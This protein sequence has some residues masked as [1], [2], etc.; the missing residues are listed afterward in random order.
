MT[1]IIAFSVVLWIFIDRVKKLWKG[2]KYGSIIT[3]V[4]A[5]VCGLGLAFG[6]GL[7]LLLALD[8]QEAVTIGGQIFAGLALAGGSSVIN[9]LLV[10][11]NGATINNVDAGGLS[12]NE[13][14]EQVERHMQG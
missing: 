1:M 12:L 14:V 8:L 5:A 6:Y 13:I 10:K 9:E 2:T 3:S 4:V 11:L 7:D